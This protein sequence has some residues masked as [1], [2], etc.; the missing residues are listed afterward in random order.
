MEREQK[1]KR[2]IS[3]SPNGYGFLCSR[4]QPAVWKGQINTSFDLKM[5]MH[6]TGGSEAKWHIQMD[7]L[8]GRLGGGGDIHPARAYCSLV[9]SLGIHWLKGPDAFQMLPIFSSQESGWPTGP[10]PSVWLSIARWT[11][12]GQLLTHPLQL[13]LWPCLFSCSR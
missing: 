11:F 12:L 7:I 5:L 1:I 3:Y 10:P 6:P 13:C 9:W 4:N 2:K 8:L